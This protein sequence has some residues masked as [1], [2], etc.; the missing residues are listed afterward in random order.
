MAKPPS[1]SASRRASEVDAACVS[2][3]QWL[4]CTPA[5]RQAVLMFQELDPRR[6][7]ET[8]TALQQRILERFP[9]SGLSRIAEE[10]TEVARSTQVIE[11][12]LARPLYPVRIG[13]A[14]MLGLLLAL[15]GSTLL[16]VRIDVQ[17][18]SF[19]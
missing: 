13:V 3:E 10:L 4:Y 17:E 1:R 2:V 8:S 18:T 12:W 15:V 6:I 5:L 19:S 11:N 14:I 9:A 16:L 7:V